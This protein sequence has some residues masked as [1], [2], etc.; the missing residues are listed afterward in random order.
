MNKTCEDAY[1]GELRSVVH[2]K[3][4]QESWRDLVDVMERWSKESPDTFH[5]HALPYAREHATKWPDR[6]RT[7]PER[8]LRR[9]RARRDYEPWWGEVARAV[10]LHDLPNREFV[11][12]VIKGVAHSPLMH[13][14]TVLELPGGYMRNLAVWSL[15]RSPYLHNLR[16]LDLSYNGLSIWGVNALL[17]APSMGRL[18]RLVL[19]GNGFGVREAAAMASGLDW[20][21]LTELELSHNRLDASAIV[22]LSRGAIAGKLERLELERNMCGDEGASALGRSPLV[23]QLAY[24]NMAR[25]QIGSRGAR[26]LA[27]LAHYLGHLDLSGNPLGF[28]GVR[29]LQ[30]LGAP[31]DM[32][33]LCLADVGLEM[34][35]RQE[36]LS[37]TWS[38][39]ER[40]NLSGNRLGVWGAEALSQ[41]DFPS[42]RECDLSGT[43]LDERA[44]R[45][46]RFEVGA[47]GLRRLYLSFNPL[48]AKG[49]RSCIH[50]AAHMGVGALRLDHCHIDETL[51]IQDAPFEELEH[52]SLRSNPLGDEGV[53]RLVECEWLSQVKYL[54]LRRCEITDEGASLIAQ[55]E[56][57]KG[58][59]V[60]DLGE[61]PISKRGALALMQGSLECVHSLHLNQCPLGDGAAEALADVTPHLALRMLDLS[62]ARELTSQGVGVLR[63]TRRFAACQIIARHAPQHASPTTPVWGTAHP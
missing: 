42:L 19:N 11:K 38:R 52:L 35:T 49:A 31:P 56:Y 9:L 14:M 1:F 33:T 44:S 7:L 61:N 26:A 10:Q 22:A 28:D 48:G 43:S 4:N 55:C 41:L 40:L 36:I 15:A 3:P 59:E 6:M 37:G 45:R 25:N 2:R 24:V 60:L 50:T 54:D 30:Q 46:L 57:L 34:H 16:E 13:S 21:H 63:S 27:P 29:H 58:L 51:H 32:K 12:G 62:W 5:E 47:R 20:A 17:K 8:W 23:G 39:L 53:R 18:G